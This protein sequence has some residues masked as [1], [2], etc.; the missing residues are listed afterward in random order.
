MKPVFTF[1]FFFLISVSMAQKSPIKFGDIPMEDMTMTMYP[2]DSSAA[3]VVLT[4]YGEAYIQSSVSTTIMTFERH[5]RI[6]ILK[7]EGLSW[8]N[9]I[10]PLYQA[11]T[12]EEKVTS[13]KASTYNLEGGKIVESKMPKDAIFKEKFNRNIN[14]HKFTLP[15]VK[16]G[17]VIEYS[18]KI[19][20][21][22]FTNFPNWAFQRS[23][24]TRHSEYWAIMP[25]FFIYE[26][27]MQ[28]YLPVTHYET[29]QL[30]MTGYQ[31]VGHHW[32]VKDAP[33]FKEE[34]YMT[35]EE[36][37]ISKINF[38]L[39]YINIPGQISR[40]IMGSWGKL[41]ADLLEYEDFYGVIKGSGFLKNQ[42]EMITAGKNDPLEKITA[43]HNFVKE[44]IR[45]DGFRD[46]LAG[47]LKKIMEQKTGS[48]GDINL[49]L[50]SML[51]K[52]GFDVDMVLLS[53]RDHGFVRQA[54]PMTRQFNYVVCLVRVGDKSI[55]LDA[56]EKYLPVNV[57]PER[58]LN[59]QGLLVSKKNQGWVNLDTRTKSKTI[60]S[61]DLRLT[62]GG[63]LKGKLSLQRDGYDANTMRNK[64][65]SEGEQS[66]MKELIGTRSWQIEKSEFQNVK[67]VSLPVKESHDVS[68]TE[69]ASVSGPTIYL[70]P[71]VAGQL[72]S[73][74]F[75]VETRTYP[76]D[77]GSLI[78][79]MYM[80][81]IVIPEGYT[82]DEAPTSR[83][84]TLPSNSARYSYN[85]ASHGNVITLTSYLQINRNIFTQVEYPDLREFY[86]QVVAKQAEQFVFKKQ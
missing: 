40:E 24:P 46:F 71:F 5:V 48:S 49:L 14:H 70:N 35:S 50:A 72:E 36:D 16:E 11:G 81:K 67:E 59:G 63:D 22:F 15:N 73:N 19:N 56:T 57:L 52:A 82:L 74:P 58:C 69:H 18:F 44:N 13:L 6:K 45:W 31:A 26:R 9:A 29:K 2:G 53:T 42:V 7:K 86:N 34:P 27:Y 51:E 64:Y 77:F 65:N 83:V 17:S 21:E 30:N 38:A 20:S 32:I 84:L 76:V 55:F 1:F 4:D 75:K 66:Y 79:K 43:I 37:Y 47:N 61:A 80:C 28:G 3:A 54:Y 85:V 78:E 41:A 33:A 25:T 62:D 68:I 60:I 39:A 12:T 23:I 8:A 10:I